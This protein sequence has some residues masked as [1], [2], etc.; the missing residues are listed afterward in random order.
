MR[1][2]LVESPYQTTESGRLEDIR[3]ALWAVYD[4][5]TRG[6]APFA[7][8]LFY[9]QML[10]ETEASRNLGLAMRDV[11]SR[12]AATLVARYTDL[13]ISPGM[14]RDVDSTLPIE[15]RTLGGLIRAAW[16]AGEWPKG[17]V[18]LGLV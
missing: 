17:S 8:H 7:S 1:L 16:L 12:Q 13:G 4:S 3:Y 6:E 14:V 11:F 15:E 2:V 5:I 9:T 10:P 18:R